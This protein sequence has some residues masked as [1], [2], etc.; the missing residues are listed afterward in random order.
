[1]KLPYFIAM[2]QG[3][4]FIINAKVNRLSA[5]PKMPNGY[6]EK[7][8]IKCKKEEWLIDLDKHNIEF[9]NKAKKH[10]KIKN[11]EKNLNPSHCS[12]NRKDHVEF[13]INTIFGDIIVK[14]YQR[15]LIT[16]FNKHFFKKYGDFNDCIGGLISNKKLKYLNRLKDVIIPLK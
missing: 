12:N 4:D 14:S 3:E 10:C 15:E 5:K 13:F 2:F 8:W 1:M 16:T 11:V 9:K 7:I 6:I